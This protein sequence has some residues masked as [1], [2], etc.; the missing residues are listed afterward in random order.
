MESMEPKKGCGRTQKV[1]EVQ[2]M[3]H[4]TAA[5]GGYKAA[6]T[7]SCIIAPIYHNRA[8]DNS[9]CLGTCMLDVVDA[10]IVELS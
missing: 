2:V 5:A 10:I 9:R 7:Q 6:Y 1:A 8:A 4:V 3:Y